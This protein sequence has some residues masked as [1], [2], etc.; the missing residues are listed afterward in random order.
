MLAYMTASEVDADGM[1]VDTEPSH[2]CFIPF[3]CHVTDGRRGPAL[4]NGA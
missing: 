1:A 4:Q 3:C 2:Q